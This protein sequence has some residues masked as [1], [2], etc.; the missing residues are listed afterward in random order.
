MSSIA[1]IQSLEGGI[2]ALPPDLVL[3][4]AHF[5]NRREGYRLL[6]L[7]KSWIPPLFDYRRIFI[8][9]P[10]NARSNADSE[11]YFPHV[12]KW[13][14]F[15]NSPEHRD[16]FTR[17]LNGSAITTFNKRKISLRISLS[18][19]K[20]NVEF[21]LASVDDICELEVR[22]EGNQN[23]KWSF[24]DSLLPVVVKNPSITSLKRLILSQNATTKFHERYSLRSLYSFVESEVIRMLEVEST[25]HY[26]CSSSLLALRGVNRLQL[27]NCGTCFIEFSP[28]SSGK[29]QY[30]ELLGCEDLVDLSALQGV[31][32]IKLIA[33]SKVTDVQPLSQTRT[34]HIINCSGITDLSYLLHLEEVVLHGLALDDISML[35]NV[36]K[37][38]LRHCE[39]SKYPIP[40]IGKGQH[41]V[42]MEC[43]HVD[44]SKWGNLESLQLRGCH[45]LQGVKSLGE[46]RF[47]TIADMVFVL[48]EPV[49]RWQEWTLKRLTIPWPGLRSL[50]G[51][52]KVIVEECNFWSSEG[53]LNEVSN[54][55]YLE[56]INCENLKFIC[57]LSNIQSLKIVTDAKII[58]SHLHQVA[59]IYIIGNV[60]LNLTR[61]TQVKTLNL[62]NTR[63]NV[64]NIL[65]NCSD[66]LRE[67]RMVSCIDTYQEPSDWLGLEI[68]DTTRCARDSAV[69]EQEEE[70]YEVEVEEEE[71]MCDTSFLDAP[72]VIN[73]RKNCKLDNFTIRIAVDMWCV[74]R[75]RATA[76][77]GD[78]NMWDVSQVTN[79]S[80]LFHGKSSFNSD[81][82]QWDVSNV[83]TMNYMFSVAKKFDQSLNSWNV[84]KVTNMSNMFAG[85]S[86][87]NQPLA[88]WDISQVETMQSMF[89]YASRFN[90]SLNGWDSSIF[91]P[92]C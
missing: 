64:C 55:K 32:N 27:R 57:A 69:T 85:A 19:L 84:S 59:E 86:S 77:Y 2:C 34:V 37:L 13:D 54:I 10:T 47:L 5:L 35:G 70:K 44:V 72:A 9:S 40:S 91:G 49:G 46:I 15:R 60:S 39:V 58:V 62:R 87:F 31:P 74:W 61:F 65:L 76:L 8:S 78:I 7:C 17:I 22:R 28:M 36:K 92:Q 4:L 25:A 71:D 63:V 24:M 3:F 20:G 12:H 14:V 26:E 83:T 52:F 90:Q 82:S 51:I 81:I 33:C 42:I 1:A 16:M 50:S 88:S 79:M 29:L 89:F 30:V 56:C 45:F 48:P 21:L 67:L 23:E 68:F 80:H 6:S 18:E 73:P 41:W 66:T 53:C 38:E 11:R 43:N 75:E